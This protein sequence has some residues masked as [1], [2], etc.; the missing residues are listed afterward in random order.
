MTDWSLVKD[1]MAAAIDL[2]ERV[3]AAGYTENDRDAV[4][5][6]NGQGVSVYELLVSA[7]TYPEKIR[8]TIIRQRHAKG[9]DLPYVPETARIL[10]AMAQAAAELIGSGHDEAP[11][12]DDV[13]KMNLW[14]GRHAAPRIEQA[15]AKRRDSSV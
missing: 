7:W 1:M 10:V 12:F 15:I 4:V 6:V 3:E 9:D 5:G 14:F 13:R 8:Y 2:C 11:V